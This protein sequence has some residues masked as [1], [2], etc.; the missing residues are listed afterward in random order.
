[1]REIGA[2]HSCISLLPARF[3]EA[4]MQKQDEFCKIQK[5]VLDM[6]FEHPLLRM[7]FQGRGTNQ[8]EISALRFIRV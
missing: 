1:M 4:M 6:G 2:P 8:F 5:E 7:P 3:S